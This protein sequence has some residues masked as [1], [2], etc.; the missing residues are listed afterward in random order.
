MSALLLS[1]GCCPISSIIPLPN[2]KDIEPNDDI[3]EA[4]SI[5]LDSLGRA[6]LSGNIATAKDIDVYDIGPVEQGDRIVLK[7]DAGS[8]SSLDPVVA[9]FD[10][11]IDLVNYNDDEDYAARDFNSAI[12]HVVRHDSDHLY[13]GI[14][15]SEFSATWTQIGTYEAEIETTR[16]GTAPDPDGQTVLLDFDGSSVDIPGSR[17][18]NISAFDPGQVDSR[19]AGKDDEVQQ[20]IKQ[21]LEDRYS[22]YD[23]DFV[24]TGDATLPA[25]GTY[26]RLVFG[27][28]SA[29][30]FGLAQYSD[31]YNKY[32]TDE[33]II[34][35]DDWSGSFSYTPSLDALYT[36]MG[37]VA[38]HEL[39]HLLGLE[40]TADVTGL[41]DSSG[42]ADTVLVP[43]DFKRSVLQEDVFPFGW[44]DAIELLLDTLGPATGM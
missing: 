13:I 7:V 37:N 33:A 18:Y 2:A 41:M 24:T 22:V 20:N 31:H 42:T 21:V 10:D 39:G 36:S 14:T 26:S 27:G 11:N 6:N 8:L 15:G 38:A 28:E 44:Q 19:L 5:P 4:V 3:T 9:L 30:L 29:G 1:A 34:F 25:E 43:Q 23:I 40:H 12:D 35:T 32:Y 16:G 17:I